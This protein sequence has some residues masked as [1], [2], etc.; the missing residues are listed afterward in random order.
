MVFGGRASNDQ[1]FSQHFSFAPAPV[2][3]GINYRADTSLDWTDIGVR[4]GLDATLNLTS[5][6]AIGAGGT[7]GVAHRSASLSG[8]DTC[9]NGGGNAECLTNPASILSANATSTPFLANA[10]ARA[11]YRPSANIALRAFGGMNYDSK[12]PGVSASTFS[13]TVIPTPAPPNNQGPASGIKFSSETSW[14]AGGGVLVKF[15]L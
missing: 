9:T 3:F 10:E 14:Y 2:A 12:V 11:V 4:A 5:T 15:G 13:T 8:N 1:T 6:F 7:I